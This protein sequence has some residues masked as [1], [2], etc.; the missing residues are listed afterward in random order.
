M[1]KKEQIAESHRRQLHEW[2]D[3]DAFA[4]NKFLKDPYRTVFVGRLYYSMSELD[5]SKAFAQ[6]GSIDSVRIVRHIETGASRGYG[7][8]V[9]EREADAKNCI[10]ELA[11]TGLAVDPPEG[12]ST[13]RKILVDMERGRLVRNWRPRRLDGGL[14]GRHYTLP[15]ALHSKDASAAASGRRFNLPQNPY[16]LAAGPPKFQK[17][18]HPDRYA[19]SAT[20]NN[21]KRPATDAD[22]YSTPILR[23]PMVTAYAPTS[24]SPSLSSARASDTSVKD[25]YAKYQT[26]GSLTASGESGRSIRS[27]RGRE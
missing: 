13:K 3:T 8:V 14:G 22:H 15:S 2:E 21:A 10:R 4:E 16:Q 19:S 9:F 11:P 23:V 7:F 17:R 12:T 6:Y 18:P 24:Q 1:L 25:K 26:L 5:L 20:T 27:I